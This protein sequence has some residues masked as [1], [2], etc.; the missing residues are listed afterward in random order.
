M[1]DLVS[2]A[3]QGRVAISQFTAPSGK[4]SMATMLA[5]PL[6]MVQRDPDYLRQALV[7]WRRVQ[8]ATG[9]Y[10]DHRAMWDATEDGGGA[11]GAMRGVPGATWLALMAYPLLRTTASLRGRPATSGWHTVTEGR[12]R[13]DELRLPVWEQPLGPAGIVALI[14]HPALAPVNAPRDEPQ[15]QRESRRL[16]RAHRAL[17]VVHVCRARRRQPPGSKSAGVLT[18]VS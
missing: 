6:E 9:E 3:Q 2:D 17:G 13:Y 11:T 12:R 7:G 8:G 10:L 14:E 4:Q 5:K 16:A 1:T 18:P 15:R